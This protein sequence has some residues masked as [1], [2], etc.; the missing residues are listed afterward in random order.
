MSDIN[1]QLAEL[2]TLLN[3]SNASFAAYTADQQALGVAVQE[4]ID[5][6]APPEPIPPD[7]IP[8]LGP[9]LIQHP[10][11]FAGPGWSCEA[12]TT[13]ANAG[14]PSLDG[15]DNLST[16]TDNTASCRHIVS[17]G[18]LNPNQAGNYFFSAYLRQDTLRYAQL[19]ISDHNGGGTYGVVFDLQ[20]GVATD[21]N[22]NGGSPTG[23]SNSI[24]ATAV[25][26]LYLATVAIDVLAGPANVY[27]QIATSD[28]PTPTYDFSGQ[29]LYAG[30]GQSIYAWN[31]SLRMLQG[32][33]TTEAPWIT[34]GYLQNTFHVEAF[35]TTNVDMNLTR[36]SGFQFYLNGTTFYPDTKP[37]HVSLNADG[38]VTLTGSNI[39]DGVG[40][41]TISSVGCNIGGEDVSDWKGTAFGGGAYFEATLS[42][43][44]DNINGVNGAN[45]FPAWWADPVEHIAES[46][47]NSDN[48]KNQP[49]WFVHFTE[50]D[51]F[52]YNAWE[53]DGC[54][55]T[56][57][58]TVI[59]WSGIWTGSNYPTVLQNSHNRRIQ[60]PPTVDFSQP[61]RY[62]FLWVPAAP[63]IPGYFQW[64]FDGLPTSARVSYDYYDPINPPPPPAEASSP[65]LYGVA[66][67]HH[68]QLFLNPDGRGSLTIHALDVWQASGAGNI[69][70]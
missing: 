52:E 66:D 47:V 1:E 68:Y 35:D 34:A 6:V 41:S 44:P 14:G 30:L 8:V 7:T 15:T 19:S 18:Q 49:Q 65:W 48:W 50:L 53:Q 11:N 4:L 70:K 38:S 42:F 62:G 22:T 36:N 60:L 29:P 46:S 69:V 32:T 17:Q 40:S 55:Y 3:A 2:Q 26:G 16:I 27:A 28:S 58:G 21:T 63:A 20:T 54:L 51:F 24:V 9:N 61:H 23:T 31:A 37:S 59:D 33:A 39:G 45:G 56:Y 57:N 67:S 10:S 64:Y 13:L 25:S 5:A 12:A 43:D